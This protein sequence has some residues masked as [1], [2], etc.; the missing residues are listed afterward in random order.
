MVKNAIMARVKPIDPNNIPLIRSK[1]K[2]TTKAKNT[3]TA[4]GKFATQ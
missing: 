1:N 3:P 2:P 4:P